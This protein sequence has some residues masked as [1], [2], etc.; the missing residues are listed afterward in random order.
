M[1]YDLIIASLARIIIAIAMFI[2][3]LWS[4]YYVDGATKAILSSLLIMFIL[5]GALF[6]FFPLKKRRIT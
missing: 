6:Y 2:P 3:L 4:L 5:G 1:K